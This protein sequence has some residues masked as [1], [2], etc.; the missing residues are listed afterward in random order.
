MTHTRIDQA[1]L[2]SAAAGVAVGEPVFMVNLVRFHEHADY[3][4][5]T[6]QAPCSGAE[7]YF[8]RYV[9][10]F[11]EVV[12]RLG[13]AEVVYGGTAVAQI[14]G[15]PG[16]GWDAAG[17]VR[18]PNIDVFRRLVADPAYLETAEPHRLASL[19]DWQLIATTQV[20]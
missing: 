7:A 6:D 14:V 2:D 9:P 16:G 4:T 8:T 19:A 3:G 20:A 10:A 15:P 5:G 12:G 1:G 11:N 17:V 18:Y 13:G